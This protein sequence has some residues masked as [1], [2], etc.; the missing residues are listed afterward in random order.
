MAE[1]MN[2]WMTE[3]TQP[4]MILVTIIIAAISI[5]GFYLAKTGKG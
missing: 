3:A 1:I 2:Q 4:V 5:F